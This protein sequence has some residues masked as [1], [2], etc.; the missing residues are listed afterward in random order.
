MV[1]NVG[2]TSQKVE[3]TGFASPRR[4]RW[5]AFDGR[6]NGDD[7]KARCFVY[8]AIVNA[9]VNYYSSSYDAILVWIGPLLFE[10]RSATFSEL[11]ALLLGRFVL[12]IDG[13]L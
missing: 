13:N 2:L 9:R 6:A 4:A 1:G 11:F 12:L 10:R 8:Y 3:K 7:R 5:G